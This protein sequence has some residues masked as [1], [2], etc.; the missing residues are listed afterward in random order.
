MLSHLKNSLYKALIKSLSIMFFIHIFSTPKLLLLKIFLTPTPLVSNGLYWAMHGQL[1]SY[2]RFV[3]LRNRRRH[4]CSSC[5]VQ[6]PCKSWIAFHTSCMFCLMVLFSQNIIMRI[7]SGESRLPWTV[8]TQAGLCWGK[9]VIVED[10]FEE[11]VVNFG[12]PLAVEYIEFKKG[13]TG[14]YWW[15]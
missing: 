14:I 2:V 5:W 13:F 12:D 15:I 1:L 11:K 4:L 3:C 8:L 9:K 10:I 6:I 7:F